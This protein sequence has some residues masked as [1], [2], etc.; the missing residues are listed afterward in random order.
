MHFQC[1]TSLINMLN[2]TEPTVSTDEQPNI[3]S[4]V[5][6]TQLSSAGSSTDDVA[7]PEPPCAGGAARGAL[8]KQPVFHSLHL[9]GN[10]MLSGCC[11]F[12]PRK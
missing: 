7:S 11:C 10:G 9:A 8:A 3:P 2:D 12:F 6:S 5:P 4:C 1:E